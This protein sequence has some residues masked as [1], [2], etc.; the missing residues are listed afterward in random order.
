MFATTANRQQAMNTTDVLENPPTGDHWTRAMREGDFAAAWRVSDA[1]LAHRRPQ[2]LNRR[3]QPFHLRHVWSGADLAGRHVLVRCYHGL[4]DTIQFIRYM[5]MLSRVAASITVQAVPPLHDL[6]GTVA[7]IDR[8]VALDY[9]RPDP[10]F[11]VDI[12]LMELPHAFRT[13]L[14]TIPATVPYLQADDGRLAA[15]RERIGEEQR[16]KVGIAWSAGEWDR[17]RVIPLAGLAPLAAVPGIALFN[18]QRGPALEE[19]AAAERHGIRFADDPESW[20]TDILDTAATMRTLDLVISVDT[21]VAHLAGALGVPVW[22]LLHA[23]ADWRWMAGRSDS[24]W[25][26]TMRLFR[27]ADPG[28][29]GP[30]V[31]TV[32][33]RLGTGLPGDQ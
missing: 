25:Y 18:L 28:D 29:W 14:A 13:T 26:P 20:T 3:D 6:L 9:D 2:D 11:E 1:V 33:A 23:A 32:A 31:A 21:M 15:A 4:G 5:P 10:P 7:G 30:V 27:Q 12:E 19:V 22:T 24:P 17:R 8:I 16:L